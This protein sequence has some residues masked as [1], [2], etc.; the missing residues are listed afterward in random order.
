[1]D[2][3]GRAELFATQDVFYEN[4][5]GAGEII[6]RIVECDHGS[7]LEKGRETIEVGFRASIGVITV[8]PEEPNGVLP[9]A[10][11]VGGQSAMNLNVLLNIGNAK[12]RKK[13]IVRGGEG[14]WRRASRE[15]VRV[16][17][18]GDH[19]AEAV[20]SG[21]LRE[22]HCGPAF[23]AA[24]FD[25]SSLGGKTGSETAE[26]ASFVFEEEAGHGLCRDPSVV[27]DLFEILWQ[28]VQVGALCDAK[29]QYN[30]C[31]RLRHARATRGLTLS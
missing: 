19:R 17:V 28:W 20:I 21:D 31:P 6:E 7:G 1:V 27:D 8:D 12:R 24:Y 15:F 18:N 2:E 10:R 13:I 11:D 16:R 22:H 23:E 5:N 25:D 26:E 30:G 14:T 29:Q 9:C 4:A 3:A